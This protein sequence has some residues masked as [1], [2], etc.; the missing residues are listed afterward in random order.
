MHL[1][2][3]IIYVA[4]ICAQSLHLGHKL[5]GYV[6]KDGFGQFILII[7]IMFFSKVKNQKIADTRYL[8]FFCWYAKSNFSRILT[9]KLTAF[10]I[11]ILTHLGLGFKKITC[12]FLLMPTAYIYEISRLLVNKWCL[13]IGWFVYFL[14]FIFILL[15]CKLVSFF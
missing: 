13:G 9:S 7:P 1:E 5:R 3:T 8:H 11:I 6:Q 4:S 12:L 2:S 10:H 15:V 14:F